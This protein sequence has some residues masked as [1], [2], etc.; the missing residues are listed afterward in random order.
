MR[1]VILFFVICTNMHGET[2]IIAHRGASAEAPENTISAFQKAIEIGVN[3]V[4]CDVHLTKDGI[5]VVSHDNMI[6]YDH[7]RAT[8][9]PIGEMAHAELMV[10]DVGSWFH[11]EFTQEKVPRLQ[12]VARLIDGKTHLMVELKG[13]GGSADRLVTKVLN[14][15]SCI[16]KS[17]V[18]IGSFDVDIVHALL[19]KKHP[20]TVLGIATTYDS[21]RSSF[22]HLPIHVVMSADYAT[23]QVIETFHKEGKKVWTY[24]VDSLRHAERLKE[25]GVDGII[26]NDP[27]SI[28]SINK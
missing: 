21:F 17:T 14:E 11:P 13:K 15:L 1:F 24:T 12:D 6:P 3:C 8:N 19:E 27:R 16:K 10:Y 5:P 25:Y 7:S 23:K 18:F 4:E 26:T 22:S 28:R 2:S 9:R 20:H